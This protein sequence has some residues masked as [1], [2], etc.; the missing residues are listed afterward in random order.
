MGKARGCQREGA[1][2]RTV[3][4]VTVHDI[5]DRNYLMKSDTI[6]SDYAASECPRKMDHFLC[7]LQP[8][9]RNCDSAV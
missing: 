7:L 4:I 2:G 6:S 1:V 3:K 5:L 8:P 9:S